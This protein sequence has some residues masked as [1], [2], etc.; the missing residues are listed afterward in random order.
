M[1]PLFLSLTALIIGFV[2]IVSGQDTP[3]LKSFVFPHESA[4]LIKHLKVPT[5]YY[6]SFQHDPNNST[7]QQRLFQTKEVLWSSKF[8]CYYE[9]IYED[10]GFG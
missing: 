10:T 8:K 7:Q 6:E 3:D 5:G 9:G 4:A 2:A 1:K